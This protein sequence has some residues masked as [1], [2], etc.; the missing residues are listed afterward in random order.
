MSGVVVHRSFAHHYRW[1]DVAEFV[2]IIASSPAGSRH[3]SLTVKKKLRRRVRCSA[4]SLTYR[5][6][7]RLLSSLGPIGQTEDT[8]ICCFLSH[9]VTHEDNRAELSMCLLANVSDRFVGS[10][11]WA[12]HNDFSPFMGRLET[13]SGWADIRA[14][15]YREIRL[16]AF[17]EWRQV[18]CAC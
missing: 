1:S 13:C 12:K 9:T 17:S 10:N 16:K 4:S 18:V 2:R 8:A 7:T 14:T 3:R 15:Q 5:Y 11:Q 6:A